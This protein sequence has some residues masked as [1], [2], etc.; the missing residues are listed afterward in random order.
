MHTEALLPSAGPAPLRPGRALGRRVDYGRL[1]NWSFAAFVFCGSVAI[2]EPSPYDFASMLAI[3]IWFVGGFKVHRTFLPFFAL[4][5]LYNLG[6]FIGLIPYVAEHDPT[7]F[8]LQSLYLALTT[9]VFALFFAEDT[10]RRAEIVLQFYAAST[11]FAALAGI[12]GYFGV[13]GLGETL[14]RYGRASGTFKDPNVLGSYLVMGAVYYVQL[15]VLGRTRH[16]LATGAALLI[17]VAGILLSFSRGSWGAFLVATLLSIGM[18][19]LTSAEPRMRRRI[20][21][22][23]LAAAAVAALAVLVLLA[24]PNTRDF[25]LQRAALEQDYDEGVTGRFGNQ[26]RSIPIL[27]GLPNGFGPLRFRLIFGLEPHNSYVNA[28]ASYG[29]LGGFAFVLLVAL[30]VTIGFRVA[31]KPSPYRRSAQVFWPSLL[32]FLLQGFQIDIDHW[33]HVFLML[34]AVWGIETARVRWLERGGGVTR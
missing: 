28:F 14:S 6:G 27:L 25:F 3:P 22:V 13:A 30:T 34:G 24:L 7:L 33:R 23:A 10:A 12:V 4:I 20:V 16:V 8:M 9:L 1:V 2:V 11:V 21:T 29:W 32:V 31:W 18:A 15:I 26:L 5:V 17:V 19:F